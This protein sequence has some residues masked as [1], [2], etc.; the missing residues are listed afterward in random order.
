MRAEK[1]GRKEGNVLFNNI[2]KTIY[3]RLY[4]VGH[5]AKVH[6][7]SERRNPLSSLYGLLFPV[8]SNT[9]M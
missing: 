3:L 9:H 8:R 7:D 2:L 4:D 1:K 6:S 5:M